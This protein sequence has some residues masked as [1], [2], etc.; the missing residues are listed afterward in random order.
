MP[1]PDAS[2][3][4]T[5]Q[6]I[7]AALITFARLGISKTRM[8]DIA[9]EAGLSKGTLYLYFKSKDALIATLFELTIS[10]E[11]VYGQELLAQDISAY[12]KLDQLTQIVVDD[13]Q[14]L[15]PLLSIYF[16][17]IAFAMR[18][19]TVRMSMQEQFHKFLDFLILL[20]E[21]GIA[22][23]EFRSVDTKETALMMG[24]IFEGTI[25]IWAYDPEMVDLG[26]QMKAS[27]GLLLEGLKK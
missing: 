7:E 15:Q 25:L 5:Q 11:L 9:K 21:Q 18:N 19:E 13:L 22:V 17:F 6:I 23:G 8:E 27:M 4:R 3:E 1:R 16:E 14:Q 20:I 2:E 24:T 26:Q 12:E 10:R